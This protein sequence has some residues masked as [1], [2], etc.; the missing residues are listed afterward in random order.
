MPRTKDGGWILD[1]EELELPTQEEVE[2]KEEAEA[3]K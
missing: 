1:D 2:R 3:A